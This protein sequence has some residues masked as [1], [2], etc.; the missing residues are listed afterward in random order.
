MIRRCALALLVLA[1]LEAQQIETV[2][3]PSQS[4]LVTFRILFKTGAAADPAGKPGAAAL[5]A[6]MLAQGGSR[7]VPYDQIVHALFPIAA[8]IAS[9]VDKEMTVFHGSTHIDNLEKYYGLLRSMLLDP[10]WREDDFRRLKT[11][12]INHLRVEL[13]GN[14]DEELGKEALYERIYEGHPYGHGSIGTVSALEHMTLDD[15]KA[16]YR[17]NYTRANLVIGLT[18]GFPKGFAE[19]VTADFSKLPAGAPRR[20]ELPEP[21]PARKLRVRLIEKNTRATAISMGFPIPINRSSPEW[22]ALLVAQSYLGQHRSS[23]GHLYHRLRELRG[24]NYGDYAYIEYFP[25]GMFQFE[26][27]PNLAR[28]QQIFQIWIRPVEPQ[29][30]MFALRAALYE[31]DKLVASGISKE[32]FES[33]RQ[34]LSKF[35]NLLTQTQTAQ[36]GYAIDSKYYGIPEFNGYLKTALARLTLDDVNGAIR[37]YLHPTNLD[38][39][40]VTKDA[41]AM[42]DAI[43]SGALSTIVYVSPKPKEVLEED[44][45]VGSYKLDVS[46]V[47]VVPVDTVFEK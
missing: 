9:Q 26:P 25:R 46:S 42:K 2:T 12:A 23:K 38:I 33:T 40:V 16:F 29:N 34:F 41:Q 43:Q 17:Q 22:P 35:V 14:N 21:K 5:T 47:D 18:G 24:L 11:D 20:L 13:R 15:L 1:S 10:G 36:L 4:P 30:G 19:K 37:K 3:L 39:I 6:A 44:K 45:L 8:S 7:E 28:R 32:D 31:L 27:D